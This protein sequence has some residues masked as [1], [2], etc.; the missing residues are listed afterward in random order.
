M[1]WQL[2]H[3]V[4]SSKLLLKI[5]I[6]ATQT[7]PLSHDHGP[8]CP[9]SDSHNKLVQNLAR[10]RGAHMALWNLSQI[11]GGVNTRSSWHPVTNT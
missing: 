4:S 5:P 1:L 11:S 3:A 2:G 7:V 8:L 10:H 6:I 9:M